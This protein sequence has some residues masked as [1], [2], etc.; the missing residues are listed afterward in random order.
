MM[1]HMNYLFLRKDRPR[2]A[3]WLLAML[4]GCLLSA[5]ESF[6]QTNGILSRKVTY[7]ASKTSMSKVLKE[8]RN[9]TKVRFTYNS[10][11]V[12]R[13]QPVTINV[14]A[15]TLREFLQQLLSNTDLQFTEE[16]GG[17]V[18]YEKKPEVANKPEV[19]DVSVVMRGR[20]TDA[21]GVPLAGVS[22]RGQQ[23][24]QMTVTGDDG[25]FLLTAKDKELVSFSRM[26]MK[27]TTHTASPSNN[28]VLLVIKMDSVVRE[29]QEVVVNGYQKID[30][31]LATGSYLKLSGAEVMQPGVPSIDRMLQGR[32]P[33]L[34]VINTS[35]GVNAKA[36]MRIRGTSTL[37][38]NAAPL[39]VVDG[40]IRPDPVN[41]SSAVL[42]NLISAESSANYELMGNA[43]SGVNPFDIESLT[44][45]RDAAATAIY[46]SRAANGIIVITTKRGKVGQAQVM[47]NTNVSFQSVPNYNGMK[48]MNSKE[49]VELSR[50]MEE[51]QLVYARH[52]TGFLENKSY[53]GLRYSLYSREISEDEFNRRVATLETRNTDWFDVLF[54]NQVSTQHNLSVS[55]G[56][57]KTTYYAS[58]GFA[59]NNGAANLDGN[60]KYNATLNVRTEPGKRMKL[61]VTMNSNLTQATGYFTS[62]SPFTYALQT[63]R[64]LHP[65]DFYP[66]GMQDENG[67]FAGGTYQPPLS[68]FYY[69]NI[70]HE[71]AHSSNESSVR[72]SSVNLSMDYKIANGLYFRNQSNV[73]SD[74]ADGFS[75]IDE[76]TTYAARLRGWQYGETPTESRKQASVLPSGGLAFINKMS[77]LA[78]GMRNSIDYSRGLFNQRDQFN[79]ALGNEI[80]SE[81]TE[82]YTASEPGYFPDRGRT[83]YGSP[84][85]RT[86][87]S[88]QEIT[89][90][91]SNML[92]WYGT[93]AY[94]LKNR[95]ILSTTVRTDGSNRFGQYSNSRFRPNYSV[96]GRWNVAAEDWFPARGPLSNLQL[97]A[98]YGTQGN[99]VE[100]VGPSLIAT[101]KSSLTSTY[102]GNPPILRIK[103]LPYPDLR[104]EK[105][106]QWNLGM[107]FAMFDNRVRI[108]AE[109]YTKKSVDVLELVPIPYEYGQGN[110]YRNGSS[111]YNKGLEIMAAVDVIRNKNTTFTMSV[112]TSRN[113]NRKDRNNAGQ[114]YARLFDGSG[115]IAGRPLSGFYSYVYSGLN[116]QGRPTFAHMDLPSKTNDPEKFLVYSGQLDPKLTLSLLPTLTYKSFSLTGAFFVSLGSSKRLNTP[117]PQTSSAQTVPSPFSNVN[118]DYLQR[119]R[120][121]GDEAHTDVPAFFDTEE[122]TDQ[123]FYEVP[124]LGPVAEGSGITRI[125]RMDPLQMYAQSDKWVVKNDYQRCNNLSLIYR[126]PAGYLKTTGVKNLSVG[127]SVNNV[128]TIANKD[129]NG[130]D[131]ETDGVGTS[132]L[133]LTRQFAFSLNVAF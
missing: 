57:A 53:E 128:F 7:K 127:M 28:N 96:S 56:S 126:V 103:S 129:L 42:N 45:L 17:I 60:K 121:P 46:G 69:Y 79:I 19:S 71:I 72:S 104:W 83:F 119:W 43:I 85:S 95:Y 89:D 84:A 35:G 90:G 10:E 4:L 23:S 82:G 14:T 65:D 68:R 25:M 52:S 55:G 8:V 108:N 26:G 133:P 27:A 9:Q 115:Y 99:V 123:W 109:Y 74:V 16:M 92:S 106:G 113:S 131:P 111:L 54:R 61:D 132:A 1:K 101:Y 114:D 78:L 47:Y 2:H 51:D 31:R 94:N 88:R 38:G 50:Q 21:G 24:S 87:F 73:I 118:K 66:V 120:K 34:T 29:I 86:Q 98:S 3:V 37:V 32:V 41:I 63:S 5:G 116:N 33:G 13:Q 97:R 107:D 6:G 112:I 22:V 39:V 130:Q 80:R 93:V 125:Y 81:R 15:V 48:L 122:R 76:R 102:N 44:F 110:M 70:N 18:I 75:S 124:W 67:Q 58:V 105:T 11:L 62:L 59:L 20:V 12:G 64:T 49:R 40:M 36:K 77:N 30:P 100:A 91:V 117:F